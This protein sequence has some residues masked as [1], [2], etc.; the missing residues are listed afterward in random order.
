MRDGG[1]PWQRGET[2]KRDGDKS[3][4][5]WRRTLAGAQRGSTGILAALVMGSWGLGG[6]ECG[7]GVQE[8]CDPRA[9]TVTGV[10]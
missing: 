10:S 9:E 5:E 7:P 6:S 4:K 1:E 3:G 2:A 8:M